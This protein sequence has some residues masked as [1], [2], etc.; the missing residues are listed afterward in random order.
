[1]SNRPLIVLVIAVLA[2]LGVG[3]YFTVEIERKEQ[4]AGWSSEA[5][6]NPLLAASMFLEGMGTPIA[7]R[8]QLTASEAL[9]A[10]GT[11]YLSRVGQVLT[12]GQREQ[13]HTWLEGGGHLVLSVGHGEEDNPLLM[14]YDIS[15]IDV[16]CGCKPE[17]DD[18]EH[19]DSTAESQ[20]DS[21][22]ASEEGEAEDAQERFED[23]PLS[24]QLREINR[25]IRE[26]GSR[27][28]E[29][30][31]DE[32]LDGEDEADVDPTELTPLQF[33]GIADSLR[34]QLGTHLVLDHPDLYEQP[35]EDLESGEDTDTPYVSPY[36]VT[37]H[38]G[39]DSG[40][41]FMQ[42][43]VGQGL[44]TVTAGNTIFAN[45]WIDEQDHAYLLWLLAGE[46]ET[47][48]LYS[49]ASPGLSEIIWRQAPHLVLSFILLVL[50]TLWLRGRR[51]G[52]IRPATDDSRRSLR[53]HLLSSGEYQ[54]RKQQVQQLITPLQRGI[55]DRAARVLLDYP[56]LDKRQRIE[57][58]ARHTGIE[59]G[60][61]TRALSGTAPGTTGA[62]TE[63]VQILKAIREKL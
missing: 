52:P 28:V 1:M 50:V 47:L 63:H 16:D 29:G 31:L 43:A 60:L 45:G 37:Y 27:D 18:S 54:W 12:D 6:L 23:R 48:L 55:H 7:T 53:E 33:E 57:A 44:L 20:T 51:F 19:A 8:D 5:R 14:A 39:T 10:G 3:L 21:G 11:V 9:P 56:A 30:L 49:L 4:S 61:I 58:L 42:V 38:A 13:L 41:H 17:H 24:E 35:A 36:Q 25:K 46:G 62:F 22:K 15:L 34:V 26:D 40:I 59:A 32:L 2:G